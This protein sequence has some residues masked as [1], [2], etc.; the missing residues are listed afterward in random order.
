M[1]T[2][3]NQAIMDDAVAHRWIVANAM[4]LVIGAV[5]GFAA[6][7]ADALFAIESADLTT[8]PRMAYWTI[9]MGLVVVPVRPTGC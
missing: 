3:I 5:C 2:A 1:D 7:G 9:Q 6:T 8:A 4:V